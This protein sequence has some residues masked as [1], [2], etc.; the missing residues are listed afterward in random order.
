M[1]FCINEFFEHCQSMLSLK[2]YIRMLNR[3]RN[4]RLSHRFSSP[5][6]I[7][8]TSWRSLLSVRGRDAI[9]LLQGVTTNDMNNLEHMHNMYSMLLNS[10]GRVMFD[11][12]LYYQGESEMF[13]IIF[14][15]CVYFSALIFIHF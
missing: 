11:I 12:I 1:K 4:L 9:P 15:N 13:G 5:K 8:L 6:Y 7:D 3:I 10:K 2:F 14:V